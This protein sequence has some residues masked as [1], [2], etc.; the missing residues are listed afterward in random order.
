M[1]KFMMIAIT[2]SIVAAFAPEAQGCNKCCNP[3]PYTQN[4]CCSVVCGMTS[5]FTLSGYCYVEGEVC[6]DN[7]QWCNGGGSDPGP[8]DK[9]VRCD[10]EPLSRRWL[11]VSA[12]VL[13]PQ[14]V[15]RREAS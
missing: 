4:V 1:R 7:D 11:L 12:T 14:A 9:W 5:C 10:D 6:S 8:I 3:P 13:R 2:F 15:V